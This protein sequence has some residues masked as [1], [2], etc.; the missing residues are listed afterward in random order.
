MGKDVDVEKQNQ[1]HPVLVQDI[2]VS[3]WVVNALIILVVVFAFDMK[4]FII[5]FINS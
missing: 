2:T 1:F 5:V 4:M 3:I